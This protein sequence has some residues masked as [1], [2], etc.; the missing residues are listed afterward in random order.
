MGEGGGAG[1]HAVCAAL[2][3]AL[4]AAGRPIVDTSH[5]PYHRVWQ[6]L[7]DP[8]ATRRLVRVEQR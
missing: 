2:Q 4:R 6:L 1:I 3:D 7:R 5:N 8:E